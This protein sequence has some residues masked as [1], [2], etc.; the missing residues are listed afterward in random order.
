MSSPRSNKPNPPRRINKSAVRR[1]AKEMASQPQVR[2]FSADIEAWID[3]YR[4]KDIDDDAW[5]AIY[6]IWVLTLR[7]S[8]LEGLEN[9][10]KYGYV[11]SHYLQ[12]R[13]DSGQTLEIKNALTIGGVDT[14]Y[15]TLLGIKPG[16]PGKFNDS[17]ANGYRSRMFRIVA[18]V[19]PS[20]ESHRVKSAGR[21]PVRDW[22]NDRD[23][24]IIERCV[25]RQR[26][27]N[28]RRQL[29]A[30]VGLCGGAGLDHSEMKLIRHHDIDDLGDDGIRVRI[31][32]K[33]ERWVMVHHGSEH[34]VRI[35]LKGLSAHQPIMG[36]DTNR[37]H[38]TSRPVEQAVLPSEC[39][40]I[41]A[42]QLRTTWI[43]RLITE[44][45][46]VSVILTAA[47]LRGAHTIVDIARCMETVDQDAIDRFV[48]NPE[49]L[50]Q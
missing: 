11:I 43:A 3:I 4:P 7:R 31:P 24:A 6:P 23:L 49:R 9:I 15:R 10:K 47:G 35:G 27:P 42:A 16:T 12:W 18:S 22:Y 33:R 1:L 41:T 45:V 48:R 26:N 13:F 8:D 29:A 2:T 36:S 40:H 25:L 21:P 34:L 5:K 32:G 46:P 44:R 30:L 39:P 14:W 38:A 50:D 28:T 20:A 17:T 19:N 37:K